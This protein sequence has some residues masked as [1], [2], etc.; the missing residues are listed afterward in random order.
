MDLEESGT[1]LL[2]CVVG[3]QGEEKAEEEARISN[4]ESEKQEGRDGPLRGLDWSETTP[5]R[6]EELSE[7]IRSKSLLKFGVLL[8]PKESR[9]IRL[10]NAVPVGR[11]SSQVFG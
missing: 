4:C 5:P 9:K 3:A 10:A 6:G 11:G 8:K 7:G 2:W 1:E